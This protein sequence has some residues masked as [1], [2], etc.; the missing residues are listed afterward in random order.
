MD[1]VHKSVVYDTHSADAP[2]RPAPIPQP[3]GF[4]MAHPAMS[5]YQTIRPNVFL[6]NQKKQKPT[7]GVL[8]AL[9]KGVI[10]STAVVTPSAVSHCLIAMATAMGSNIAIVEK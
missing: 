6:T 3:M 8:C 1:T 5:V 10:G 4:M 2:P 7:T 9:C